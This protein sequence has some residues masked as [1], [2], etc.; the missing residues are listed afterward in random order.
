[1][2]KHNNT[3]EKP[4]MAPEEA[5]FQ[6]LSLCHLCIVFTKLLEQLFVSCTVWGGI[7]FTE[8]PINR[9][10]APPRCTKE[11]LSGDPIINHGNQGLA[12]GLVRHALAHGLVGG[13]SDC[14]SHGE[15][16]FQLRVR[17]CYSCS[18]VNSFIGVA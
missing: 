17:V 9:A 8:E 11:F 14:I 10:L 4:K 5:L 3:P 2:A 6:A 16:S 15:M 7:V 18:T 12:H 13:R 1:M